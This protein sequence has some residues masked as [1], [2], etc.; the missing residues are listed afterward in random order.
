MRKI[1]KFIFILFKIYKRIIFYFDRFFYSN[2]TRLIFFLNG[3]EFG[4]VK[5]FGTPI[6]YIS[7]EGKCKIGFN[8]IMNNNHR[9]NPIGRNSPCYI[10]V[11]DEG[12][13]E[14]ADNVGMS[15]AAIVCENHI[16]IGNNVL[17]GGGVCIYDTDFHSL[18]PNY[19]ND[20]YLDAKHTNKLPVIIED[21]VFIGAHSTILKGVTIGENSIVGACSV[22]TKSI[23]CNQ[24]WAGNPAK[25]IRFVQ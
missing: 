6:V 13:L 10:V 19:R 25:F 23:P 17:L 12:F 20:F 5:S 8:L 9:F 3:I 4:S 2:K 11:N 21:N 24:I 1:R 22:V 7:K 14:I 15:S 16:S 18:N